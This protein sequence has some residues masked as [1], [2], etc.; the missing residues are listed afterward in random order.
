MVNT[1]DQVFIH[2]VEDL[3]DFALTEIKHPHNLIPETPTGNVS[4][5][6]DFSEEEGFKSERSFSA[7]RDMEDHNDHDKER[8]NTPQKNQPWLVRDTLSILG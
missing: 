3:I 2:A 5:P 8:G 1:P 6:D 4:E 7:S